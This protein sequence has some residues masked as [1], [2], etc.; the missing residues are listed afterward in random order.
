MCV[1]LIIPENTALPSDAVLSQCWDSNSDGG[2]IMFVSDQQ[3]QVIQSLEKEPFLQMLKNVHFAYNSQSPIC[4]HFRWATHG[5][6]DLDN[7]HPFLFHG[8]TVAMMHNGILFDAGKESLESDSKIFAN[9][10]DEMPW[11]FLN[12]PT[13]KLLITNY[14]AGDK[15]V[16]LHW[17]K[18]I[19]IINEEKGTIVDG[20]WFSNMNWV[21]KPKKE[22]STVIQLTDYTNYK[23]RWREKTP[24]CEWCCAGDTF[25]YPVIWSAPEFPSDK[26]T[27]WMCPDCIKMLHEQKDDEF[28][29]RKKRINEYD[30]EELWALLDAR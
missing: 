27:I 13:I 4:V 14:A 9:M 15:L 29:Y 18:A 7:C 6:K 12:N 20:V 11:D 16:F 28:V 2:G 24:S 22:K 5:L 19:T 21:E 1:I 8:N 30:K 3:I 17:N 26:C 10:L 25:L 23:G